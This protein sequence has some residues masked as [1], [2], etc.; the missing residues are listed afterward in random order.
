MTS[1][2]CLFFFHSERSEQSCEFHDAG[3]Q[4]HSTTV[5]TDI[6]LAGARVFSKAFFSRLH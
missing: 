1:C 3:A 2:W 6:R 5:E 4:P